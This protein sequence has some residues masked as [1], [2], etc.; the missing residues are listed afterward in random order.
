LD[1]TFFVF[2]GDIFSEMDLADMYSSHL[3]NRASATIALTWVDNP[4]AFGVVETGADLRVMRFVEKPAPGEAKTN[5]INA[6]TYILE[7]EVLREIPARQHYMFERGLFPHL[8]NMGTAV[9]G[10]PYRGYWLDMGTPD[11]YFA[12]NVDLLTARFGTPLFR[13]SS[14]AEIRFDRAVTLHH[15]AV[16]DPP[17]LIG[18]DCRIGSGATLK[19]P[20]VIGRRCILEEGARIENAVLWDDVRIGA[21]TCLRNC[22]I[23]SGVV[24]PAGQEICNRVVTAEHNAALELPARTKV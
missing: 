3:K 7:P 20:L 24:I 19:G 15:T 1:G 22:I 12:L 8:L 10:Y 18:S 21:D 16:L 14:G 17:V 23:G 11:K 5:W 9:Y 6:G 2:N 13:S 4:S